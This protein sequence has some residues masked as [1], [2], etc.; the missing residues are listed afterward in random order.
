M[1]TV[2]L[3]QS[4]HLV[5]AP[6]SPTLS[7]LRDNHRRGT[8]ADFLRGK[9]ADGSHLSVVTAYFTIFAYARL[10]PDL[11]RIGHLRLLFGE[12]RFVGQHDPSRTDSKAFVVATDGLT[13]GNRLQLKRAARECAEWIRA[14]VDIR[15][16]ARSGFLHG[17][18]YHIAR[19]EAA[20]AIVGSSNFTV[21]GLGLAD[22]GNNIELNLEVNDARDR[23]DVLAW[24]DE[25]WNDTQ[26]VTDVKAEVLG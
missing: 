26:L 13:L 18:L 20:D 24:F 22:T 11:D 23:R 7:S 9:I 16:V 3:T 2:E 14:R 17:K 25:I 6:V 8:V 4:R 19:G 10:K 21:P 12:P 5:T 15:T 1:S